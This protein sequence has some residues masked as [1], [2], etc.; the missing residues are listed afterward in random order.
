MIRGE[1]ICTGCGNGQR[2][3][4][5]CGPQEAPQCLPRGPGRSF[6]W[7]GECGRYS[8]AGGT[9]GRCCRADILSLQYSDLA[10]SAWPNAASPHDYLSKVPKTARLYLLTS[11]NDRNTRPVIA[12]NYAAQ[13]KSLGLNA[14]FIEL[15]DAGH[16]FRRISR[17]PQLNEVQT[18]AVTGG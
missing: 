16:G 13:A 7:G 8:G 17:Q 14:E 5:C 6:G 10:R 4:G 12:R 15:P 1:T 2:R 9:V 18:K 3:S 11:E